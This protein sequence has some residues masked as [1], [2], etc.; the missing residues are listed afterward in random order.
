MYLGYPWYVRGY[1]TSFVND[2]IETNDL[3][4][5]HLLGS[6]IALAGLE[7]RLPFTG[8]ERLSLISSRY[9]LTE[10]AIFLDGGVAWFDYDQFKGNV[11]DEN[12][13]FKYYE[14]KPVFSTGLSL[15]VNLFGALVLE[16]YV[17]RPLQKE[18]EW[19]FGMNLQPGW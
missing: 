19:I 13:D 6:K 7:V 18:T 5:D 17:S 16:P 2:H 12:D 4:I 14:A 9:F 1:Q 3:R 15:R 10:F 8:P 11:S